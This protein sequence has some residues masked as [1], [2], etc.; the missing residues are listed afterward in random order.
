M[1]DIDT[2]AIRDTWDTWLKVTFNPSLAHDEIL[3]LCD[4]LDEARVEI[5][6]LKAETSYREVVLGC[7]PD[8]VTGWISRAEK[9]EAALARVE[10]LRDHWLAEDGDALISEMGTSLSE[11]LDER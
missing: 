3:D 9:A 11:A 6:N 10:A 1:T 4:A 7:H 5:F 8:N 2:A